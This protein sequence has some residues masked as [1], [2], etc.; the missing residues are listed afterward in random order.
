MTLTEIKQALEQYHVIQCEMHHE[1]VELDKTTKLPIKSVI[2][3]EEMYQRVNLCANEF[4]Q[5]QLGCAHSISNNNFNSLIAPLAKEDVVIEQLQDQLN[6]VILN[7]YTLDHQK[8]DLEKQYA[9]SITP[10]YL[11]KVL[12]AEILENIAAVKLIHREYMSQLGAIKAALIQ[13]IDEL[14][15]QRNIPSGLL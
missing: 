1:L 14:I 15:G 9:K 5:Y 10:N 6:K 11:G 3:G 4:R 12:T 13:R 7:I 2:G 8:G